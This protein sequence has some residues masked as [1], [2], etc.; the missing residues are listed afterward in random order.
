MIAYIKEPEYDGIDAVTARSK[1]RVDA[2][3]IFDRR[4]YTPIDLKL[5]SKF[6]TS[7]IKRLKWH[8]DSQKSW[9]DTLNKLTDKDT[10]IIQYPCTDFNLLLPSAIKS[11][12]PKIVL[13]IH[14]WE[15]F[16]HIENKN[17]GIGRRIK[18]T[19]E[20]HLLKS[21]DRI[22][23]HN[24]IMKQKMIQHGIQSDKLISLGIFDYLIDDIDKNRLDQR[25]NGLDMPI[26]IAG[27][28]TSKKSGYVYEL[29]EETKF[30][31]F[32]AGYSAEE[33]TNIKYWGSFPPNDLPYH[34]EGSFGLVWDGTT[35]KTCDGATGNYLRINNPHKTS[36]Y[37]ASEI[38]V[39]I[40]SQAALASYIKANKCGITVDSLDDIRS[41]LE[42]LNN[43]DYGEMRTN[44]S[45]LATKLRTGSSL[46]LALD[47][48]ERSLV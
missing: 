1:A 20:E 17:E 22:I 36:L 43:S 31:L 38:P 33:K 24:D 39:I 5:P 32:G 21:A 9:K 13:L 4:G 12:K 45:N 37:L 44:A 42:K 25:N 15:K 18:C 8:L 40:W 29:P 7:G 3:T 34:M 6:S 16:R 30:N 11:A 26:I 48:V 2:E 46:N 41:E 28:L 35:S 19:V 14:D 47:E 10:L 27:N 23:T